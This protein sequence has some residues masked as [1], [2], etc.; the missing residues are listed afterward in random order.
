M[1]L[2]WSLGVHVK[3]WIDCSK[4]P[5]LEADLYGSCHANCVSSLKAQF[6]CLNVAQHHLRCPW[7]SFS[8]SSWNSYVGRYQMGTMGDLGSAGQTAG[9]GRSPE[10]E[11]TTCSLR[12]G[13]RPP[14]VP[15][16]STFLPMLRYS[17]SNTW[18]PLAFP[19]NPSAE[20]PTSPNKA[21]RALSILQP[22]QVTG[23]AGRNQ[24]LFSVQKLL[25][26]VT[27]HFS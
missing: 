7:V 8:C 17:L 20:G 4:F 15:Y 2:F 14:E 25:F 9:S 1:D 10:P 18:H 24:A 23:G 11:C 26:A 3:L 19:S 5:A 22:Q 21:C 12:L 13:K 16:N 27:C 6:G